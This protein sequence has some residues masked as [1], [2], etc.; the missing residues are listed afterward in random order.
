MG[1]QGQTNLDDTPAQQDQT[2]GS[3]QAEDEVGQVV[4]DGK[5]ITGASGKSRNTHAGHHSQ[6]Q[7]G[8]R[9]ETEAL[10]YFAGHGQLIILLVFALLVGS[11]SFVEFSILD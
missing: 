11:Q 7:N 3:N 1:L 2:D 10:L 4:D 9:I 5:G 8:H 6:C